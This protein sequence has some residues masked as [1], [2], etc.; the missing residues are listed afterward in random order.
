MVKQFDE[1]IYFKLS[2]ILKATTAPVTVV[3][4]KMKAA[5]V[6]LPDSSLGKSVLSSDMILP[7]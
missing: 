6:I 3:G 7:K 1:L 2:F 5:N 4:V